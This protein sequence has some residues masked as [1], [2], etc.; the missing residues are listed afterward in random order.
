MPLWGT[1]AASAT[2]KP[3]YLPE[4]ENSDY[5]RAL[6]FA[7]NAGWVFQAGTAAS[8][9]DNT[10]ANPEVLVAIG[11]L[12]GVSASTGLQAPTVTA[13]RFVTAAPAD[14]TADQTITVEITWDE[15]VTV[16]GTPQVVIGNGD[17]SGDGDGDYTLSYTGTGTTA[18]RLRF[19]A[20]GLTCSATDVLTLGGNN[21]TLNGGT[22]TDTADGSTAA[23]L[24]L[25]GLTAVTQTVTA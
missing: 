16:S 13:I 10:S 4:D 8:G 23:S 5:N 19:T 22:I 15:Q 21:V 1:A 12:A 2:N 18:N 6:C 11:D 25:S 14:G 7:T 20:T 17:E 9:N 24:V 3:K